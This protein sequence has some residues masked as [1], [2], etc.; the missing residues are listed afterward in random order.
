MIRGLVLAST[1]LAAV[2]LSATLAQ[3][4]TI[5]QLSALDK[6]PTAVRVLWT[7]GSGCTYTLEQASS[8]DGPWTNIPIT[9]V[10]VGYS[11]SSI[12]TGLTPGSTYWYRV[13]CTDSG[14][15]TAYS[16]PLS[17]MQPNQAVLTFTRPSASTASLSWTNGANYDLD[18]NF[19]AYQ[20]FQNGALLGT[21][22][23]QNSRS[24]TVQG[25]SQ[26]DVY[27]FYVRTDDIYN[28]GY[29]CPSYCVTAYSPSND[30]EVKLPSVDFTWSGRDLTGSFTAAATGGV[31]P[32]SFV[33]DF[34][35]GTAGSGATTSH[36]YST[37]GNYSVVLALTD[38]SGWT[39]TSAHSVQVVGSPTPPADT[40]TPPAGPL[41]VDGTILAGLLLAVFAAIAS[42]AV[43]LIRRRRRG[44]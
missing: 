34:G 30:V 33:W 23:N 1:L 20:V 35:D 42:V 4:A 26:D 22:T 24:Y 17:V 40:T 6:T 41:T 16:N 8:Q 37:S 3:G 32:Y 38:A 25:L 36:A 44:P 31:A 43:L 19:G 9:G 29:V 39:A 27:S 10:G 14:G 2:S 7:D 18:L 15:A 5:V 13:I 21:I 12:V 28:Q 11:R